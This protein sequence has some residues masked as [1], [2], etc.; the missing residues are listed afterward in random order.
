MATNVRRLQAE[1][2]ALF[3][4]LRL[5]ALEDAPEAF[6]STLADALKQPDSYWEPRTQSLTEPGR[7][8][9]F[10]AQDE[11]VPV[12]LAFG[13]V[14]EPGVAHLAGMWVEPALRG[15]GLGRALVDAVI[16][17]ARGRGFARVDLWVTE[18][19]DPAVWLYERTGFTATGRRDVLPWNHALT[20]IEMTRAV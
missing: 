3:R 8:V 18:A 19:N 7:N 11:D 9:M 5:R 15:C 13:V 10:V 4:A 1:E 14:H 17:W 12:G 6:A 2:A 20:T 16:D